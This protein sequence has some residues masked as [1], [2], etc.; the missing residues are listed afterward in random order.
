MLLLTNISV[1]QSCQWYAQAKRV[2]NSFSTDE[3]S[4]KKTD[5]LSALAEMI[6][7]TK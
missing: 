1:M 3:K 7:I 5:D 4:S 6:F 2:H